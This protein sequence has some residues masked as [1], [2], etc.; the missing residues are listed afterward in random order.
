MD[1]E[2]WSKIKKDLDTI[3]VREKLLYLKEILE[4]EKEK[5]LIVEISNEL[6]KVQEIIDNEE[7]PDEVQPLKVQE[8]EPQRRNRE[9]LEEELLSTK[10]PE[11]TSTRYSIAQELE[12]GNI[13][14]RDK[15]KLYEQKPYE[16]SNELYESPAQVE[17]MRES[18]R[19]LEEYSSSRS[20]SLLEQ[21]PVNKKNRMYLR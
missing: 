5:E 11:I 14:G 10:T 15:D 17:M 21:E 19:R 1:K 6:K 9:T 2:T 13:Y 20:N 18:E 8:S 16:L 7:A 4:K 12:K 3:P